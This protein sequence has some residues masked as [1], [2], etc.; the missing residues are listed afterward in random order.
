MTRD[1]QPLADFWL[2][3]GY[4]LRES[5]SVRTLKSYIRTEYLTVRPKLWREVRTARSYSA[6]LN[7]PLKSWSR[8]ASETNREK[9]IQGPLPLFWSYPDRTSWRR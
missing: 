5:E 6:H 2:I 4:T 3:Y 7:W 8:T 1:Q 9:D